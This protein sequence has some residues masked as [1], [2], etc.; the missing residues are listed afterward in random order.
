[1]KTTGGRDTFLLFIVLLLALGAVCYLFVIQKKTLELKNV[2]TD[3][4]LVEQEKAEKDA[5]IQQAQEL[6]EMAEQLKS[7]LQTL[8]QKY[9][10]DLYTDTIS[11]KLYK[12]FEDSGIPFIVHTENKPIEYDVV[13]M[14]DGTASP[15]K[16]MH[17]SYTL[18]VSGT[19]G[20][21]LTHDEGDDIPYEVFLG[22]L[23]VGNDP[24]AVNPYAQQYGVNSANDISSSTYVGY[25]EFLAGLKALQENCPEYVK[26][27]KIEIEDM[28]Q[29]FC[30]YTVTID[31]YAYDLVDRLSK[32]NYD[33]DYLK[34]VGAEKLAT[35]GIVGLP[36]YFTV[37]SPNYKVPADSPLY[38]HYL[39]F[40]QFDFSVNRPFA[41]WRHWSY[42]W[43]LL[44]PILSNA[45][46]QDPVLFRLTL[47][48]LTGQ[49][50]PEDYAKLVDEYSKSFGGANQAENPAA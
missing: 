44:E 50:S 41:S 6:D 31:V 8:E 40:S 29:G 34:W 48:Y 39:S 15:N 10:P 32:P 49:I 42:E 45:G 21:F 5:I 28:E 14:S 30:Y 35:G 1:M 25:E 33:M 18:Q 19:D 7:Q 46:S 9:L 17:S 43:Q 2:K 23:L 3:L 4:Q 12:Y 13:S 22:Q 16:A 36:N 11:R 26:T 24:K 20:F 47:G 37:I 38:G 27:T